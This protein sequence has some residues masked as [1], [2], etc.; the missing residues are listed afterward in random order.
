MP[1]T[2]SSQFPWRLPGLRYGC[3]KLTISCFANSSVCRTLILT[4]AISF[5]ATVARA[6]SE[7]PSGLAAAKAIES[8]LVDVIASAEKS[9]VAIARVEP[10]ATDGVLGLQPDAFGQIRALRSTDD[11]TNPHFIPSEYGTGVIVDAGGLILTQY[12]LVREGSQHWV[13]TSDRRMHKATIKAADPRSGLAMLSIEASGLPVMPMG[14]GGRLRKGQ[15]VVALGNP[16][17][18]ASDGQASA[19]WGIISNLARKAGAI[20]PG[21][22]AQNARTMI[23]HFGM[24]IQTDAKLNLGTSGGALVNL[25]GKMIGLTTSLAAIAGYESS[26]G[27]AIPIDAT[28]RR[29]I[30]LLKQGR[31]VEYGLLGVKPID[32]RPDEVTRGRQGSRI[33]GVYE[34]TPAAWAGLTADDVVTPVDGQPIYDADGLMLQVGKHAADAQVRLTVRQ[35]ERVRDVR[36]RLAKYPV[37]GEKVVTAREDPW[38]GLRVEYP[39]VLPGVEYSQH[40]S[41]GNIDRR[42]CV[43]V[44]SVEEESPAWKAGLRSKMFIC[45]VDGKQVR[46]PSDFAQAVAEKAGS[47][48]VELSDAGQEKPLRTIRP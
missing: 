33:A 12:H 48:R 47:V 25:D 13:A 24:L 8:A 4:L 16:Y 42:G 27:Y 7:T 29:V 22:S 11:P 38:R 35:G 44:E 41:L 10:E 9:V 45:Q 23:H 26:A 6:Q 37:T 28:V 31:E 15:L 32:L 5:S 17:A 46:S 39:T 1:S 18:I 34:A 43:I 21:D 40:L 20:A 2:D 30:D 3:A 14:D 19:S 36:V